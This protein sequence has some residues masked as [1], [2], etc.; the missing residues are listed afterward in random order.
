MGTALAIA[1]IIGFVL[2]MIELKVNGPTVRKDYS[3]NAEIARTHETVDEYI[4]TN[5]VFNTPI[6][7]TAAYRAKAVRNTIDKFNSPIQVTKRNKPATFSD[8]EW[9]AIFAD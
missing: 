1:L 3:L 2:K 6:R 9:N 4:R 5:E 8:E 7:N